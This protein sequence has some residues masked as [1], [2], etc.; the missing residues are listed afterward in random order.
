MPDFRP[1]V[2]LALVVAAASSAGAQTGPAAT[3][4]RAARAFKQAGAVKATFEQTLNNP[5]TGNQSKSTGELALSRPDKLSLR[6]A[7]A[8]DRVVSDGRWLWV[9]LPSA[10]P[11]RVLKLPANGDATVGLDVVG[12]LLDAP[13]SKFDVSDGGAATIGG[14]A[15][16]AVVLTPKGDGQ[17][18]TRAQVW[19]DDAD[20]SVRQIALTQDSG[21]ERTW[22]MT[23][24]TPG[25]RLPASTFAFEVPSGA[26]VVDQ[27]SFRATP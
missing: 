11:G 8:G 23:S 26:K 18:I 3:I 1:S 22:R 20:A 9:Y 2:A 13:R 21:L 4:D 19:V 15:T 16:H 25:A 12:D 5:L 17:A 24:W 7:G 27:A 6:F 10:A 14:R